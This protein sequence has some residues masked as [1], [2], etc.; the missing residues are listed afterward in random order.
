VGALVAGRFLQ[1][2]AL[3][4]PLKHLE[5]CHLE[6]GLSPLGKLLGEAWAVG[7]TGNLWSVGY[8]CV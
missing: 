7:T 6:L 2:H 1:G 3:P 8:G 5:G 4:E